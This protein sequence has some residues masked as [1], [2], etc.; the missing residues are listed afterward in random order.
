MGNVFNL[1]KK[2]DLTYKI[3]IAIPI[4]DFENELITKA[5]DTNDL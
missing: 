3:E 2:K 5:K 1:E 4:K